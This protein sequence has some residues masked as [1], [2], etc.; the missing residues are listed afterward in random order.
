MSA[1]QRPSSTACDGAR[2]A[3]RAAWK[4]YELYVGGPSHINKGAWV[5]GVV[6]GKGLEVPRDR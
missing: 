6:S 1:I 3:V 4:E 5:S 2:R